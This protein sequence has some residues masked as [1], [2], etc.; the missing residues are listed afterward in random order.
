MKLQKLLFMK[1]IM[2]K[3]RVWFTMGSTI[4]WP[5]SV[6]TA[7]EIQCAALTNKTLELIITYNYYKLKVVYF[8]VE[9]LSS[10]VLFPIKIFRP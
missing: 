4:V 2:I 1:E 8:N 6:N 3:T 7:N 5:T 10:C 9:T